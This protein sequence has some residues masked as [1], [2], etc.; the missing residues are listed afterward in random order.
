ML[1]ITNNF[2]THTSRCGHATGSDEEYVLEAIKAGIKKLGFSDHVPWPTCPQP[3]IRM[4]EDLLENYVKSITFLKNKYKDQIEI[5]LG[6][7]AEVVDQYMPYYK[8]SFRAM[9]QLPKLSL[10]AETMEFLLTTDNS[11]ELS[12]SN[13]FNFALLRFL[14]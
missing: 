8:W 7:E 12:A 9:R 3:G 2:H 14:F 5:H 4:N 10:L 11:E 1:R 13:S 6:F